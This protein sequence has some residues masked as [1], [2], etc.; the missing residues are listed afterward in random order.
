MIASVQINKVV[1]WC[2]FERSYDGLFSKN[3]VKS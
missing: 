2:R 1:S 3:Y